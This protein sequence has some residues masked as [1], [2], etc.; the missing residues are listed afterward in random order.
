MEKTTKIRP[1]KWSSWGIIEIYTREN[2]NGR[3]EYAYIIEEQKWVEIEI[4]GDY[5]L[6]P[7]K[8]HPTIAPLFANPDDTT[9][10]YFVIDGM[11]SDCWAD[12]AYIHIEFL[13][14][15]LET[16]YATLAEQDGGDD[17]FNERERL[18][19]MGFKD[20]EDSFRHVLQFNQRK[21][22]E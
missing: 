12:D 14:Q 19:E 3:L 17:H 11:S 1:Y 4:K 2:R 20:D 18:Y 13:E 10:M 8:Q 9:D 6:M 22:G 15:H 21:L 5:T 16:E 7:V